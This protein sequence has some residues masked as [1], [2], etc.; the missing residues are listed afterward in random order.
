MISLYLIV[1]RKPIQLTEIG[2]K[3]VEQARNIVNESGRIK[4]IVDQQ[5][6]FIGGEFRIGII[7]TV[8]P[9]LITYVSQ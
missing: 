8:M 6:G 9:T 2:K 4:D 1:A 3:I 7:P 5:K